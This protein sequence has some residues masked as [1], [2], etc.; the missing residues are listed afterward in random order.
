MSKFIE[1]DYRQTVMLQ[2]SFERQILPDTFEYSI[3]DLVDQELDLSI[4][5]HRF[6]NDD[7]GRPGYD[8]GPKV[9]TIEEFLVVVEKDEFGC[10]YG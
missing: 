9:K 2:I 7:C 8:P 4:F 3:N 5:H 6:N 10:F 1:Y